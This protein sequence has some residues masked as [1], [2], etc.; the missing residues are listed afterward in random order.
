MPASGLEV[1]SHAVARNPLPFQ[2]RDQIAGNLVQVPQQERE[3]V[4]RRLLHREHLDQ[5]V[6]DERG[7][8]GGIRWT[9][10]ETK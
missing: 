5:T 7:D 2:A 8:P 6:S 3:R 9:Q 10:S 1:P 4:A